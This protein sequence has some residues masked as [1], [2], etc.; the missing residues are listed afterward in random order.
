MVVIGAVGEDVGE[1]RV[2]PTS[3]DKPKSFRH[4]IRRLHPYY[5]LLLLAI[6]VAIVEPLKMA[7]FVVVGTGHWIGGAAIL[8]CAYI[9]SLSLV[10]RLFR[11]VQP[12]LLALPWFRDGRA[13]ILN[14]WHRILDGVVEK[15]RMYPIIGVL[16]SRKPKLGSDHSRSPFH[17]CSDQHQRASGDAPILD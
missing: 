14:L 2:V 7:G 17:G 8:T 13:W 12:R 16:I 5:C 1:V 4:S 15:C 10:T 6:P 3:S 11:I 9:L